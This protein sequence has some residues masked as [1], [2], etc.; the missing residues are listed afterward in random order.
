MKKETRDFLAALARYLPLPLQ[1][2]INKR[3]DK[4]YLRYLK[5]VKYE[6]ELILQEKIDHISYQ[7]SKT[8][9]YTL[10]ID[11]P[12]TFNEKIQ[13]LKLFYEDPLLTTCADKYLAR[14]YVEEKIGGDVLVPLIGVYD[15]PEEIDFAAL[16]D[17]FV[18]KVNWGS[19]SNIIC[20][21]K[22]RLNIQETKNKLQKWLQK[23]SNHYYDS[24]E[25]SYKILFQR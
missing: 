25:F 17:R 19:G 2:Y 11:T 6:R 4:Q 5:A 15:S 1:P 24:L 22:K 21:D 7:F 14:G 8:L 20:R 13:W 10:D 23:T 18:L 16:P 3:L 9:G 12:K